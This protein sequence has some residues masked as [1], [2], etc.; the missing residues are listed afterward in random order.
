LEDARTPEKSCVFEAECEVDGW[1]YSATSR[2]EAPN[3]LAHLLVST[4]VV[5]RPVEVRH[6]GI[7]GYATYGSLYEMAR[8]IYQE[9]A[10]VPLRRIRWKPPPD[11]ISDIRIRNAKNQGDPDKKVEEEL[12]PP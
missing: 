7:K 3:E 11:L 8:S 12:E 10:K 9:S 5:D 1:G 2:H 4:G 6:A